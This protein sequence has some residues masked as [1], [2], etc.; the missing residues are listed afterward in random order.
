VP[1][2]P[3]KESL[4][5]AIFPLHVDPPPGLP[6]PAA[7]S[8]HTGSTTDSDS[9]EDY[10]TA[11]AT[12]GDLPA[13]PLVMRPWWSFSWL[14]DEQFKLVRVVEEIVACCFGAD[15]QGLRP[16]PAKRC[17]APG[18]A[19][20]QAAGCDQ[21]NLEIRLGSMGVVGNI[22]A[23]LDRLQCALTQGLPL[24]QCQ[25]LC[26]DQALQDACLR[27]FCAQAPAESTCWEAM[28]W[29]KC[30]RSPSCRW[31]HPERVLMNFTF[32]GAAAS[33]SST[34]RLHA[35]SGD[36]L[37]DASTASAAQED[38]PCVINAAAYMPEG[39]AD[40]REA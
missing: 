25:V 30:P 18:Q 3:L 4:H 8:N 24:L 36:S 5:E 39:D 19:A 33:V 2:A 37:P 13:I 15:Y 16:V 6:R 32:V 10:A 11:N 21:V 29:G 28:R 26:M 38:A 34:A 9:I 27:V 7:L 12:E 1:Q 14:T 23:P 31:L 22:S 40:S 20:N 35:A 17:V